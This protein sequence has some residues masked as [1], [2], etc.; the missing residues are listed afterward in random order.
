MT[1]RYSR[2][3]STGS[4]LESQSGGSTDEHLQTLKTNAINAGIAENDIE[5]GYA[6]DAVF[7]GWL[8]EQAEAERTY[9]DKR[10]AE[11]DQMGNQFEMMF[12]DKRDGT[13]TWV[14]KIN[15]IKSR[16]PK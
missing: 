5:V 13:T 9:A 2:Q 8:K 7:W 14:D 16:Y 10:K 6:D 4:F 1:I 3:I 12:D 15:E 11:Y